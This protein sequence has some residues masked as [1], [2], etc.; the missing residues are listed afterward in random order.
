M[1]SVDAPDPVVQE[2]KKPT[3][4][5][6]DYL[7]ALSADQRK[8]GAMRAGRTSLVVPTG[9]GVGFSGRNAQGS[10]GGVG[11]STGTTVGASAGGTGRAVG[12]RSFGGGNISG[13]GGTTNITSSGSG[14]GVMRRRGRRTGRGGGG[15]R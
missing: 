6:N 10:Q 11:F 15:G 2:V 1:C 14:T 9:T 5:R 8:V 7:D 3:F 12:D 13:G 4:V